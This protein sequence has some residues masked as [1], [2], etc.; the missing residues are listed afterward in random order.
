M[1]KTE[2]LQLDKM[3]KEN[4]VEDCTNDI[5]QKRHSERI[6]EDVKNLLKLMKT[7]SRLRRR[8]ENEYDDLLV[9]N[10][11][12]LFNSYTDI[13]NKIKKEEINLSTLWKFLDVLKQIEDGKLNQHEGSHKVGKLLKT[14]YLDSAVRKADKLNHE[15]ESG[16]EARPEPKNLSW[17]E[18]KKKYS[19]C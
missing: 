7:K 12:F 5:R 6:R 10:C 8:S 16:E 11:P 9:A 13:F 2:K 17:A 14:L 15:R 18:Y 4:D 19:Q 1:N 3:I